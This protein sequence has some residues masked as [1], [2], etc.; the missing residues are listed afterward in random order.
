MHPPWICVSVSQPSS[1]FLFCL[2]VVFL[3]WTHCLQAPPIVT[4]NYGKLR[5]SKSRCP[6]EILAPWSSIWDSL[7]VASRSRE[8]IP[9]PG[10]AHVVARDQERHAVRSGLSAVLEDRFLLNDMMPVWSRPIWI[11]WFSTCR[12]RARTVCT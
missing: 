5:A 9:A 12:T 11:Q 10:A 6:N 1:F 4:T 8:K 2:C 3:P 7:R